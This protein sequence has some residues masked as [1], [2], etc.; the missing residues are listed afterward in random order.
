VAT[1]AVPKHNPGDYRIIHELSFPSEDCLNSSVPR[2]TYIGDCFVL[3]L[4][5]LDDVAQEVFRLRSAGYRVNL[6]GLDLKSC[7]RQILECPS[8]WQYQCFC[9]PD[10]SLYFE[11]TALMGAVPSAMKA[12]RLGSVP[13]YAHIREGHDIS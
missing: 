13:L 10:D 5:K 8:I 12:M 1:G 6:W 9:G 3:A 2:H 7:F 4:G 11:L